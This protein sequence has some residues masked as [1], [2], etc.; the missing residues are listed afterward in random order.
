MHDIIILSY[1]HPLFIP[2][3]FSSYVTIDKN[4]IGRTVNLNDN[5]RTRRRRSFSHLKYL[6]YGDDNTT[7]EGII[8]DKNNR[9]NLWMSVAN[10]PSSSSIDIIT[11]VVTTTK[12]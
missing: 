8:R 3:L 2:A 11:K 1:C 6:N 9:G 12:S 4:I 7:A 10:T 5:T